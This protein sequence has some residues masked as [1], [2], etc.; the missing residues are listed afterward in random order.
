MFK[1]RMRVPYSDMT[2]GNHVYYS[3]YLEWLEAA[4]TEAFREMGTTFLEFQNRNLMFPVIECRLKYLKAARYDDGIEIRTW[5]SEIGKVKFTWN[6][7][8]RRGDDV[9]IMGETLHVCASL[10]EKPQRL[11]AE[12]AEKMKEHL[13][14]QGISGMV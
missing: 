9:L 10:D 3:R 4:R 11:P 14:V 5:F 13:Q 6:F 1:Y 12:L 2:L 8:I 7:E